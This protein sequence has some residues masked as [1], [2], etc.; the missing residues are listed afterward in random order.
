MTFFTWDPV[1]LD[2]GVALINNEHQNLIFLMNKLHERHAAGADKA[3]LT[4]ILTDLQDY[5]IKH[6]HDEEEY[7]ASIGYPEL[8]VHQLIHKDLLHILNKFARD[9]FASFSREVPTKL[10]EFLSMWLTAHISHI[11]MKIGKFAAAKKLAE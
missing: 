7:Q 3:E 1:K 8:E 9:Y 6:F 4:K 2:V 11:D 10:F 5:T